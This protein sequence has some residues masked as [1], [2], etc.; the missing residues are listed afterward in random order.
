MSMIGKVVS[1]R[2]SDINNLIIDNIGGGYYLVTPIDGTGKVNRIDHEEIESIIGV[3]GIPVSTE[4]SI[5]F[6]KDYEPETFFDKAIG[7]LR[8]IEKA[9]PIVNDTLESFKN[10]LEKSMNKDRKKE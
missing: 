5:E 7:L 10:E 8:G 1:L 9:L 4:S 2:N 6:D 3:Y